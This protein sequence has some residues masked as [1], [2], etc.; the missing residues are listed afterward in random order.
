[1]ALHPNE[2]KKCIIVLGYHRSG[3]SALT[4]ALYQLGVNL[5]SE[6]LIDLYE[7]KK[8]VDINS[9]LLRRMDSEWDDIYPLPKD[10]WQKDYL[11]TYDEKII[12]IVQREFGR[13]TL[14]ALKDPRMCLL[15][16]VYLP[17]LR[18]LNIEPLII[19]PLR[20]PYEVAGSHRKRDGFSLE[21]SLMLWTKHILQAEYHSRGFLRYFFYFND[22]LQN[23]QQVFD[24]IGRQFG[25]TFP[26]TIEAA[27]DDLAG[28]LKPS[29]KHHNLTTAST[30]L[31][32]LPLPF[33]TLYSHMFVN[34]NV[35][36][37]GM[38][39]Q[40]LFDACRRQFENE[41]RFY[42]NISDRN[43]RTELIRHRQELVSLSYELSRKLLECRQTD[44]AIDLLGQLTRIFPERY[45]FW[46]NLGCAYEIH[47]DLYEALK[48]FKHAYSLNSEYAMA[49]DNINRMQHLLSKSEAFVTTCP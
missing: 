41:Q 31:D 20:N 18:K 14:S 8:I 3:T 21:K 35:S 44:Y 15:L 33:A 17:V 19:I 34:R 2:A 25:I 23:P 38:E 16:P 6:Y 24:E 45:D 47:G 7:N 37:P 29:K 43:T 22:L 4:G 46:N 32:G 36:G 48:C 39:D 1:M 27:A 42:L 26:R 40:W 49:L 9:E 10:F 30:N 5:G 28:F 12:E 11:K 13:F